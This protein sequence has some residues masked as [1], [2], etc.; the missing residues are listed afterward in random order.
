MKEA[1]EDFK[2]ENNQASSAKKFMK[3]VMYKVPLD[4]LYRIISS[5]QY[6]SKGVFCPVIVEIIDEQILTL[7]DGYK[8]LLQVW[9]DKG[10]MVFERALRKPCSNYNISGD[11]FVFQEETNSSDVYLVKL[12]LDEKPFVFKFTLPTHVTED[13]VNSHFDAKSGKF[14]VPKE[15]EAK[16]LGPDGYQS[17]VGISISDGFVMNTQVTSRNNRNK[18]DILE[19]QAQ[20]QYKSQAIDKLLKI[21]A[22][23]V[24]QGQYIDNL[25]HYPP[26]NEMFSDEIIRRTPDKMIDFL[27]GNILLAYRD[28]IVYVRVSKYGVDDPSKIP[29]DGVDRESNFVHIN[30]PDDQLSFLDLH[31]NYKMISIQ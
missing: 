25:Q 21:D 23:G 14:I 15:S 9:S 17:D 29:S 19:M 13:R 11:H 5:C 6:D 28:L 12:H 27:E 8:Y 20:G 10:E 24:T 2:L 26:V 1:H 30:V 3:K 7:N 31:Q 22:A 16:V 4:K 18:Q